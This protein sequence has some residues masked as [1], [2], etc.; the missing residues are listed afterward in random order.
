MSRIFSKSFVWVI[1]AC[2][3]LILVF[4]A[5]N[6]AILGLERHPV[7]SYRYVTGADPERGKVALQAYGCT[8]CHVV[9]GLRQPQGRVGPKLE[10]IARQTYI[11][12][13]LA[14]TP[15]NLILWI[16]DPP[17]FSPETAMPDLGVTPDDA[18]DIAAY[19]YQAS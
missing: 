9:P 16:Q 12:G 10:D 7:D 14:N 17:R 15:E 19:L 13:V 2:G 8:G 18:R 11:G 6:L 4:I 5:G 1:L 3:A